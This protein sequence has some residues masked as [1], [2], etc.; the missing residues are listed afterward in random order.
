M[1]YTRGP[2]RGYAAAYNPSRSNQITIYGDMG[3]LAPLTGKGVSWRGNLQ[4]HATMHNTIPPG[5]AA[6]LLYMQGNNPMG[7]YMLSR[8]PACSGGVG[9]PRRHL[10]GCHLTFN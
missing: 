5:A 2:R 9:V 7:R 1:G 6:G 8:N 3:G 10:A 4:K